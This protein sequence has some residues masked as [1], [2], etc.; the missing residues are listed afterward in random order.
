MRAIQEQKS[1]TNGPSHYPHVILLPR[2]S[3]FVCV[4][5]AL[6][7]CAYVNERRRPGTEAKAEVHVCHQAKEC[8]PV[9]SV[10]GVVESPCYEDRSSYDDYDCY[11]W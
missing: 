10:A 8:S 6:T 11:G 9:I 5:H 7:N 2:P 4:P 1:F 3:P